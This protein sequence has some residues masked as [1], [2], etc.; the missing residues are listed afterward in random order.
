MKLL[1]FTIAGSRSFPVLPTDLKKWWQCKKN[2]EANVYGK[3]YSKYYL[4]YLRIGNFGSLFNLLRN[5]N[6]TT[7]EVFL[8]AQIFLAFGNT[9]Y[10]M[11]LSK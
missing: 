4:N 2:Y 1:A 8:V 6:K 7:A 9:Y 10:A 5:F 3:P 11:Q